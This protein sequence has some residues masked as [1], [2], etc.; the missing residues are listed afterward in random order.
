M[1]KGC[2]VGTLSVR[3]SK[4]VHDRFLAI[5]DHLAF[6]RWAFANGLA[7]K[8][9][10]LAIDVEDWMPSNLV[11]IE[12][13]IT[14]ETWRRGIAQEHYIL[15]A[16]EVLAEAMG[17]GEVPDGCELRI[18]DEPA[19]PIGTLLKV[20]PQL[21]AKAMGEALPTAVAGLLAPGGE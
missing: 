5:V 3:F 12:Y 10:L 18:V 2:K 1:L 6:E 11:D 17:N 14:E 13:M 8:Q 15:D 16:D 9:I 19:R 7:R 20:D 4:A 21:V